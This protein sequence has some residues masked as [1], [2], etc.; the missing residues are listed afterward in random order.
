MIT[1]RFAPSPTGL[2]HLGHAYSA[3]CGWQAARRDGGRFLLRLEDLDQSR[4]RPEFRDAIETDLHWLGIDWDGE[5]LHQST[6]T[7]AYTEAL[8]RLSSLGLTYGCTCTRR[9]IADAARAPHGIDG[10][11]Y[12][13]T[14][15]A[16][17]L[18]AVPGTAI[19]LDL[20]K[21]FDHIGGAATVDQLAF[22]DIGSGPEGQTGRQ[23]LSAAWL[24]S[25]AGDIVLSRRDGAA[26]YHLAVVVDDAYQGVTRITRG[27]DLFPMTPIHRLLQALLDLPVPVYNHHRLITD[28]TGR[29]LAKRDDARTIAA[30]RAAGLSPDDVLALAGI[31]DPRG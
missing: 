8:D 16:R 20:A 19:R 3:W 27:H 23:A 6:R 24:A 25:R 18:A 15:R 22:D 30:Y 10:P 7:S 26:A 21:A 12:P 2:L 14:C 4:V 1:D 13:G 5:I 28:N 31:T 9:D 29:R 11:V 17:G